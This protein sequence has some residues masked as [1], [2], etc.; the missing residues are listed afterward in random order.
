MPNQFLRPA[1]V[2]VAFS[3][4]RVAPVLCGAE[5]ADLLRVHHIHVTPTH[6]ILGI[7]DGHP[8]CPACRALMRSESRS[9]P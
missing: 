6:V 1:D 8:L 2:H 5:G 7:V 3:S 9:H 4:A